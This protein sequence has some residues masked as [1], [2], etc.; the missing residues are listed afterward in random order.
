[1]I[2]C[3]EDKREIEGFIEDWQEGEKLHKFAQDLCKYPF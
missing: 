2:D 1:M 3:D